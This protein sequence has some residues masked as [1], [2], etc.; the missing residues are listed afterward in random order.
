MMDF[1]KQISIIATLI[2]IM[3]LL[4]VAPPAQAYCDINS[5][6]SCLDGFNP[7]TCADAKCPFIP[8]ACEPGAPA[9]TTCE[10][11][12]SACVT[13]CFSYGE[14]LAVDCSNQAN[15][16]FNQIDMYYKGGDPNTG[17]DAVEKDEK[18]TEII[19][20]VQ[21]I[22]NNIPS[23]IIQGIEEKAEANTEDK[24]EVLIKEFFDTSSDY[25]IFFDVP[26]DQVEYIKFRSLA[27]TQPVETP[28]TKQEQLREEYDRLFKEHEEEH[29]GKLLAG[30][31]FMFVKE[32]KGDV[33][34]KILGDGLD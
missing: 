5:Y 33:E 3:A 22:K 23:E 20:T 21:P 26:S 6:L 27:Q 28:Q 34:I 31:E 7:V 19:N 11:R 17:A 13:E 29:E 1:K 25:F 32:I 24:V 30:L 2:F 8:I 15:C 10:E 18:K 14:Q 16:T 9:N 12:D 4:L